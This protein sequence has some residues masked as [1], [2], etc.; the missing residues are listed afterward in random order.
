M[1]KRTP[2]KRT[3]TL[4]KSK[5]IKKSGSFHKKDSLYIKDVMFDLYNEHWDNHPN[6]KCEACNEQLW[7]SNNTMYHDH[8]L[9]KSD[10]PELM[11]EIDN[12]FLCCPDCHARKKSNPHPNHTKAIEDARIRFGK[13]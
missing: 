4:K 8:L 10:Y 5:S 9:E 12:L 2:F 13:S 3:S 1:L 7:G 6:K 11:Y